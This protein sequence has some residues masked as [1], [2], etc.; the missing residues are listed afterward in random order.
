MP[1]AAPAAAAWLESDVA[2]L[3]LGQLYLWVK[4]LKS[5]KIM[6]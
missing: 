6:L 5:R 2:L 3:E 1:F 4:E